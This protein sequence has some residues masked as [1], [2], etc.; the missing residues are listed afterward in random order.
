MHPPFWRTW[1]A[2][3]LYF[4]L[5]VIIVVLFFR[6]RVQQFKIKNRLVYEQRLR[7]KEKKLHGERLEFFTNISHELRTPL[8]IISVAIDDLNS[9]R[10]NN[11]RYRKSLEAATSNSNRL[12][13]LINRLLEF[14]QTETGVSSI[15][16]KQLNLNTFVYLNRLLL[17]LIVC[18]F[19]LFLP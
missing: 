2:Y 1:W 14:R 12:M 8:T 4:A 17:F 19:V 18:C 9:L 11:P 16:V 7:S 13:E 10:I 5:T 6:Y 15:K 3:L